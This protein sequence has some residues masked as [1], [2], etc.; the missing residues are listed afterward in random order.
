MW[1]KQWRHL[2]SHNRSPGLGLFKDQQRHQEHREVL[3]TFLPIQLQNVTFILWLTH[4]TGKAVAD[5]TSSSK[6][7]KS[8]SSLQSKTLSYIY[9]TPSSHL[10]GWA[11]LYAHLKL[12]TSKGNENIKRFRQI[13]THP[14]WNWGLDGQGDG[15]EIIVR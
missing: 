7:R 5:I 13:L 11:R 3:Y 15:A 12:L 8:A 10:T 4:L 6:S 14:E 1:L 9:P 2:L